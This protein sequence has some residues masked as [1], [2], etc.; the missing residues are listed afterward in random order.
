V[1]GIRVLVG[2]GSAPG[3]GNGANH[4]ATIV[5]C[6]TQQ[7]LDNVAGVA[8]VKITNSGNDTASYSVEVRFVSPD[9]SVE[10]DNAYA[11]VMDLAPGRSVI[12]EADGFG[13]VTGGLRCVVVGVTRG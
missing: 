4:D 9:G 8:Q 1:C 11:T 5:G 7:V 10:Y 6:S 12:V 2:A 13:E 3:G